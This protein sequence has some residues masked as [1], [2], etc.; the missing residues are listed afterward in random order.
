MKYTPQPN[1]QRRPA[2]LQKTPKLR[3][4]R[5]NKIY[6]WLQ[7]TTTKAKTIIEG[8]QYTKPNQ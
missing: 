6:G 7:T 1:T 2:D 3:T 5:T 4:A 8:T